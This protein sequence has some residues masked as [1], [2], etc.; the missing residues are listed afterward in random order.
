[1][2]TS[3]AFL[4][5]TLLLFFAVVTT[6]GRTCEYTCIYDVAS[7]LIYD[8]TSCTLKMTTDGPDEDECQHCEDYCNQYAP[9]CAPLGDVC[10]SDAD[11]C[12]DLCN[13]ALNP[14]VCF[15]IIGRIQ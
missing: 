2:A 12:S 8:W 9:K 5:A 10:S 7:P 13:T 15:N 14:P 6:S 11:C 3:K 1:M 4:A